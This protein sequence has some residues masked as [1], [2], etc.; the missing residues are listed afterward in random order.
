MSALQI[1]WECRYSEDEYKDLQGKPFK[2]EVRLNNESYFWDARID[3]L[4]CVIEKFSVNLVWL[5]KPNFVCLCALSDQT[6]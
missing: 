3:S 4:H 1:A 5:T 2:L 6:T